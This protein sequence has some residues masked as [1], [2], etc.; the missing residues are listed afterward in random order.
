MSNLLAKPIWDANYPPIEQGKPDWILYESGE[1]PKPLKIIAD[2]EFERLVK[3]YCEFHKLELTS[4]Q[5]KG[6]KNYL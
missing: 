1:Y 3:F 4:K 2:L 6:S 5:T